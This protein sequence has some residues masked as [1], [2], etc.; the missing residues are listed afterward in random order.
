VLAGR[1]ALGRPERRRWRGRPGSDVLPRML[2]GLAEHAGEQPVARLTF[3]AGQIAEEVG[4]DAWLVARVADGAATPVR[5]SAT[6]DTSPMAL[7][8][9]ASA[10]WVR[11]ASSSGVELLAGD[12]DA[13]LADIRGFL[14]VG[15]VQAGE[16]VVELGSDADATL[17]GVLPT[18]RA[19]AAVAVIG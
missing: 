12:P 15:L 3:L 19:L 11:Q 8:W 16:W 6:D 4:A 7:P 2:A 5:Q 13:P 18:L 1:D 9:P 14:R 10:E 17:T